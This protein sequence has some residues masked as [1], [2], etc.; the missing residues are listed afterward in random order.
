MP[1][2]RSDFTCTVCHEHII[3]NS[4]AKT[5]TCKCG[6]LRCEFVNLREYAPI[7]LDTVT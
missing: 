6:K 7:P 3:W 4:E 1:R 2:Y 5:L